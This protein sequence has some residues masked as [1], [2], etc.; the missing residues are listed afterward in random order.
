MNFK[1]ISEL[2]EI[3][4]NYN[5]EVSEVFSALNQALEIVLKCGKLHADFSNEKILFYELIYNRFGEKRKKF[6]QIKRSNYKTVQDKFISIVISCSIEKQR[7]Q[8]KT[9]KSKV[10]K[11]KIEKVLKTGFEVSS[12]A[13]FGFLPKVEVLRK[14]LERMQLGA[15]I[16]FAIKKI[17]N[18]QKA[19]NGILIFTRKN[20]NILEHEIIDG[21]SDCGVYYIEKI[22]ARKISIFCTK[23]PTKEQIKNTMRAV[24]SFLDIQVR[25]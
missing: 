14:D 5:I 4:N 22:G 18:T 21:M 15:E 7:E 8:I 3:A 25:N 23:M 13:G 20:M 1:R 24:N 10:F 16:Y 17:K 6:V 19:P 9:L 12:S 11:G 2:L